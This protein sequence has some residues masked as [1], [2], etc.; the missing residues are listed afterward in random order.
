[1]PNTPVQVVDKQLE[2]YNKKDF[3][4]FASCYHPQIMSYDLENSSIIDQMCGESFFAH[5]KKKFQ[6]NPEIFCEVT[7]RVVHDDLVLDKEY[8]K[9]C[10]GTNH[11]EMV[12]YKVEEGLITKMWYTKEIIE[13][14]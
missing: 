9:A 1:M 10:R 2:A 13:E 4:T 6:E 3:E 5:Y 8:I 11:R 12:I 7:E 14:S